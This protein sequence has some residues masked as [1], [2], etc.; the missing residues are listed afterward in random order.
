MCH[1]HFSFYHKGSFK[2]TQKCLQ[3]V[4]ILAT[5]GRHNSAMMT[6]R[7]K[8]AAKINLYRMCSFHF[9]CWN[10]FK[11][12]PLPH[13]LQKGAKVPQTFRSDAHY[14][15]CDIFVLTRCRY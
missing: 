10:Q 3:N 2:K 7:R 15:V 1:L 6:D 5:S 13:T 4:P 14:A 9:H 11:V 8:L 12:I